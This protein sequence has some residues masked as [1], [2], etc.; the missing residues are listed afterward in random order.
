MK[1]NIPAIRRKPRMFLLRPEDASFIRKT[2]GELGIQQADV[3]HELI[4]AY[5]Q[6]C[7]EIS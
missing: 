4:Q 3:I 6:K 2:S 1:K 5:L 7:A